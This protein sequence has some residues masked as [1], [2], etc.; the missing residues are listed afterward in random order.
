MIAAGRPY[1]TAAALAGALLLFASGS[2]SG[3]GS[4]PPAPPPRYAPVDTIVDSFHG[5]ELGTPV[6]RIGEID[7][8]RP[9]DGRVDGL[10]VYARTLRF[11]AMPARAYFYL[12]T[13]GHRLRR[14]KHLIEPDLAS[15]V[16]ELTTLRLMVAGTHPDL[17]VQVIRGSGAARDTPATDGGGPP[18]VR[19]PE[20]MEAEEARSRTVLFRHPDTDAVEVRMELFRRNGTPRILACYLLAGPD[21]AWPD[22]V[23]VETGP[24]LLAPGRGPDTADVPREEGE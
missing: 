7:G 24:K 12:D 20:F 16:R 2:L 1:P 23:E 3:R 4:P 10:E 21:C 19:C 17:R 22:S 11:I 14:G 18:P 8:S 15:C 13:A 5:Y 6:E 9:P